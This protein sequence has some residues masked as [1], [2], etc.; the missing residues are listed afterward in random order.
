MK[1]TQTLQHF[2]EETE[3]QLVEINYQI[4]DEIDSHILLESKTENDEN[5]HHSKM[6]Q[7]NYEWDESKQHLD[8]L[9]RIL[10]LLI[11]NE[12]IEE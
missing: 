6:D 9:N 10:V 8:N 12:L 3:S 5:Y 7:L 4:Q 1:L 2:I 11:E